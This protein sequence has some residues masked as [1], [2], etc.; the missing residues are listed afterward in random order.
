MSSHVTPRRV[1]QAAAA[2]LLV[3][4]G[5]IHLDLWN[6]G[7]KGIPTIGTLFI[8]GV[9][10]AFVLAMATVASP[11]RLVLAAGFALSIG[12]AVALMLT[13]TN[14]LFGF[15]VPL[16]FTNVEIG[17]MASE[18]GAAAALGALF[19]VIHGFPTR[20]PRATGSVVGATPAPG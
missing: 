5:V 4:Q 16:P 15:Q 17:A 18:I 12:Q 8:V 11:R 1:L 7:Y 2:L 13:K 19:V 20:S 3:A 14:G 10:A 6:G 9:V